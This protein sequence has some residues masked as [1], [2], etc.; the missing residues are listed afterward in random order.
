M[1]KNLIILGTTLILSSFFYFLELI[2]NRDFFIYFAFISFI[3]LPVTAGIL[4]VILGNYK[5]IYKVFLDTAPWSLLYSYLFLTIVGMMTFIDT[6]KMIQTDAPE[7]VKASI[8]P[9]SIWSHANPFESKE[10][11]FLYLLYGGFIIFGNM[12]GIIIRTI[13]DFVKK[14][15]AKN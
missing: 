4:I 6:Y 1:K 3:L 11:F 12:V 15:K 2:S 10:T 9:S 13:F 5:K 14:S 7:Y 8:K